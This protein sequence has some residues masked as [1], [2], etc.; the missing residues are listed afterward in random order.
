MPAACCRV[1]NNALAEVSEPVTA[2]PIQPRI[3]EKKA[4]AT[5]VPAI[6]VPIVMVWPDRF[7]T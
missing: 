3:G 5:P 1:P 6:Q 7:I 4:N 2:V